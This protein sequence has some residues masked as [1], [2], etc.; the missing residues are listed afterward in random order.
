MMTDYTPIDCGLHSQ[1][2]LAIL[3]HRK[4]RLSWCDADGTGHIETVTPTD[5]LTRNREEFMV[6]TGE[7]GVEHEIRLDRIKGYPVD[8]D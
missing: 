4:L 7:H 2:E 3:Q 8:G 6:V 1:Y 5:L